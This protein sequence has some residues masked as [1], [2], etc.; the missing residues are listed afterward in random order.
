MSL[1]ER[2][3]ATR[4]RGTASAP[5]PPLPLVVAGLLAGVAAAIVSFAALA[6]VALGAWMLDASAPWEWS[7]MLEAA[8]AGWLAGQG[9]PLVVLD[10]P[11]S[12]SPL[13]F[14][15][16]A[17]FALSMASRWTVSAAAVARRSEAAVVVVGVVAGYAAVGSILAL[18][19]RHLGAVAWQAGLICAAVAL[20]VSTIT[21]VVRVPLVS[22]E[23]VP[24]ALRDGAAAALVG[25][26]CLT[27]AAAL[28]LGA[29]LIL[30]SSDIGRVLGELNL[31]A[32]GALLVTVV[33]LGYLPTALLWA[34]AY[35]L[36]PGIAVSPFSVVTPF[37]AADPAALPGLPLLAAL[38]AVPPTG[39]VF[40]PVVGVLAGVAM[41]ALLRRRGHVSLAG[42]GVAAAAAVGVGAGIGLAMWLASG[43]L[44]SLDLAHVGPLALPTAAVA[45]GTTLLG[46]VA[47]VAWPARLTE[48]V[49]V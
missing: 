48:V 46:A 36:G 26:L 43:S 8:S 47:V 5:A 34:L 42:V 9:V 21:L 41:G 37:A 13:G 1:T 22:R 33:S 49:D 25:L 10:T 29:V 23:E 24:A 40:L 18:L 39:A 3:P 35:L 19:G 38:P 16:L 15:L 2:R 32:A 28:A 4:G 27:V 45:L 44:G 20:I 14:G 7:H 31:G 11:L 6:V 12:L 17:V 30:F